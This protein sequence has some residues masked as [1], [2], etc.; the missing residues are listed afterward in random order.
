[1][2]STDAS[3]HWGGRQQRPGASVC[4]AGPDVSLA[5]LTAH[6]QSAVVNSAVEVRAAG[7]RAYREY[8][9]RSEG[10]GETESGSSI[11]MGRA[12]LL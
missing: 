2:C 4:P 6:F 8:S 5:H 12:G 11:G 1:M 9:G 3:R 10:S 7:M